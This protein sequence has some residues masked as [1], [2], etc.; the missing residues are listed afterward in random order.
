MDKR[1]RGVFGPPVSKK[2][3]IFIDDL[4]MPALE[5]YGAQPPIELIRQFMDFNGK[6]QIYLAYFRMFKL[7]KT[8]GWY[9]RKEIGLFRL[10]E[11][12]NFICA[13]APAGGGR[14]PLTAR[15]LRHFHFLAF[16]SLENDAKVNLVTKKFTKKF[17][18]KRR[19][20]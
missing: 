3:I 1:R 12:L 7:F 18:R 5:T 10:I 17:F 16:P 15:L 20:K 11:D 19:G 9:D 2:Q 8:A 4:N 6:I 14:N 13:M